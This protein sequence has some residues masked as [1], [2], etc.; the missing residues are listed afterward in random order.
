MTGAAFAQPHI[1]KAGAT[2]T[3]FQ[4]EKS[5]ASFTQAHTGSFRT[6]STQAPLQNVS[7]SVPPGRLRGAIETQQSK[8]D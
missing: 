1:G 6:V 3:Q 8:R 7:D 5:G 4:N 2:L